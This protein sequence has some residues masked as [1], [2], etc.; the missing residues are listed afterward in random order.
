MGA[1]FRARGLENAQ[2]NFLRLLCHRQLSLEAMRVKKS[3]SE[4]VTE[5]GRGAG[6]GTGKKNP[7]LCVEMT[8]RSTGVP[9]CT[10][11][12][13]PPLQ[14]GW[15]RKWIVPKC[16][17]ITESE[18]THMHVVRKQ[19]K[20]NKKCIFRRGLPPSLPRASHF[21]RSLEEPRRSQSCCWRWR[22]STCGSQLTAPAP[23]CLSS[24]LRHRAGLHQQKGGEG[25]KRGFTRKPSLGKLSLVH[26]SDLPCLTR[27]A[28]RAALRKALR[29]NVENALLIVRPW[30]RTRR[31]P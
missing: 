7:M 26:F 3:I 28:K 22:S 11:T 6:F 1:E 16:N 2:L 4:A 23:G 25:W 29:N 20:K 9:S 21:S 5:W 13:S 27:G 8:A 15:E 31:N 17:E 19:G 14:P 24:P 10:E 30:V 18:H 12:P